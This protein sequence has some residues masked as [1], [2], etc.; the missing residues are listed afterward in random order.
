MSR[1]L[2]C[3]CGRRSGLLDE[4]CRQHGGDAGERKDGEQ[5]DAFARPAGFL[6]RL[7][8]CRRL[9]RS[10]RV[11]VFAILDRFGGIVKPF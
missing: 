7:A 8:V 5:A 2:I 11:I 9:R 4:A 1:D 3:G 10:L 6:L